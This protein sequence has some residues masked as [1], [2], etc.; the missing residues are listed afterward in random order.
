MAKVIEKYVP[1][2]TIPTIHGLRE[3]LG[4]E[5]IIDQITGNIDCLQ[6]SLDCI[7][8]DTISIP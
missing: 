1:P 3:K 5:N 2:A 4:H 6:G 7:I 8:R